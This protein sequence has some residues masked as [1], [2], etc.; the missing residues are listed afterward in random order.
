[1]RPTVGP[2]LLTSIQSPRDTLPGPAL[3]PLPTTNEHPTSVEND[4]P[5]QVLSTEPVPMV[6]NPNGFEDGTSHD[7]PD[8][9][10]FAL[11]DEYADKYATMPSASVSTSVTTPMT[12][13]TTMSSPTFSTVNVPAPVSLAA[14]QSLLGES[15]PPV[16]L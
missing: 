1:M 8:D 7:M 6:A 3:A 9:V 14:G 15:N 4:I 10:A 2:A 16:K 13:M 12:S 5:Q 11:A